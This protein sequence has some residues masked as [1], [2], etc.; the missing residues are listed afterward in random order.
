M[1][2]ILNLKPLRLAQVYAPAT[3]SLDQCDGVNESHPKTWKKVDTDIFATKFDAVN[4][5]LINRTRT[6]LLD[7]ANETKPIKADLYKLDVC[8]VYL[9]LRHL[10]GGPRAR[11][12][13]LT[14]WEFD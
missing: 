11:L 12:R 13:M 1:Q 3:S 4:S 7:G 10:P 5:C 2:P 8:G 6:Q 9:C 14:D